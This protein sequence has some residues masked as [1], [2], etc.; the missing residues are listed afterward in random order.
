MPCEDVLDSAWGEGSIPECV[1]LE[2]MEGSR[3]GNLI[4]GYGVSAHGRV[5]KLVGDDDQL[6]FKVARELDW[7]WGRGEGH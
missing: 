6:M 4:G 2:V 1:G 7:E 5:D 3:D